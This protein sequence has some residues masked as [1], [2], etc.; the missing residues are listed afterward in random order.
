MNA[1]VVIKV[2]LLHFLLKFTFLPRKAQFL[3]LLTHFYTILT[4]NPVF[5]ISYTTT[6]WFRRISEFLPTLP[7]KYDHCGVRDSD[8]ITVLYT[9][10]L[11]TTFSSWIFS[12]ARFFSFFRHASYFH[13]REYNTRSASDM[14]QFVVWRLT[15]RV[16]LCCLLKCK[17]HI[18]LVVEEEATICN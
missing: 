15:A 1:T 8:P 14:E 12:K 3:C 2:A 6:I 18:D 5:C 9:G 11:W 10:L 7:Y 4:R 16:S 17:I 13:R